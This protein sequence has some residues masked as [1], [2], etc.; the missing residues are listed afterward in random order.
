MALCLS[1]TSIN[2]SN[3][4]EFPRS[5]ERT[6]LVQIARAYNGVSY[7]IG[8]RYRFYLDFDCQMVRYR[9]TRYFLSVSNDYKPLPVHISN[10][11]TQ[12]V[13]PFDVGLSLYPLVSVTHHGN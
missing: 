7:R 10:K 4:L 9:R 12:S 13:F 11:L 8:N 3:Q 6:C 5:F 2:V 1:C